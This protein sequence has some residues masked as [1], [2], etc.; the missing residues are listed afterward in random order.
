V[1]GKISEEDAARMRAESRH[2]PRNP[3][4]PAP[5]PARRYERTPLTPEAILAH[6]D[7][8]TW[9]EASIL[10][11]LHQ[12]PSNHQLALALG[13]SE[14]TVKVNLSR[15]YQRLGLR[16]RVQAALWARDHAELLAEA[17]KEQ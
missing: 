11:L 3:L 16:S 1:Y 10:R 13:V 7:Y 6:R 15:L 5:V 9:R 8:V 2:L 12:G 17:V 4:E 14:G